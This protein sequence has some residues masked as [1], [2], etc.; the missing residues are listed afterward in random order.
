MHLE[1]VP[2]LSDTSGP[3]GSL[4]NVPESKRHS[5]DCE[6]ML[7]ASQRRRPPS[8]AGVGHCS[9]SCIWRGVEEIVYI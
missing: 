6:F 8:A 3:F 4:R 9:L 7:Q 2:K 5:M 1:A